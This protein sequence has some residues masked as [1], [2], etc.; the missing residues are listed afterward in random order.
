MKRAE[1]M[2]ELFARW[3]TSGLSLMAFGKKEG[4]SY[5]K[6]LYWRRKLGVGVAG[7]K[8]SGANARVAPSAA[9]VPVR[10]VPDSKPTAP[11]AATFEVW[12]SNGVCLDV[13]PGF[14]EAELRRLVGVL[15]SC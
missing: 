7:R 14:D 12:L 10:V 5:S 3:K 2:Q 1:E 15:H 9:V 8:R 13:A 4:V 6:L 11:R